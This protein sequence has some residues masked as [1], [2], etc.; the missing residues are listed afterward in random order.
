MNDKRRSTVNLS[1]TLVVLLVVACGTPQPTPT[2]VPPTLTPVPPTSTPVPPTATLTPLPPT[3]SPT[4][5][6]PTSPSQIDREGLVAYFPFDGDADDASGNGHH[7]TVHGATLTTDR[8]GEDARAYAFDGVD[9]FVSIP[10]SPD[11]DI[12]AG[13]MTVLLWALLEAGP[14]FRGLISHTN[15]DEAN[16]GWWWTV[17]YVRDAMWVCMDD[18][19]HILRKELPL[20]TWIHLAFVKSGSEITFYID[21]VATGNPLDLRKT[22]NDSDGHLR[23]GREGST[24]EDR[25]GEILFLGKIDDVRFYNRAFTTHEILAAM[26]VP[27]TE[28]GGA[29][30]PPTYLAQLEPETVKVGWGRFAVGVYESTS[31]DPADKM[32]KGDPIVVHGVEYPHGLLAHAPSQLVYDLGGNFSELEVTIG[33]VDWIECGDG[34]QFIIRLDG[35]EI[36]RSPTMLASSVPIEVKVSVAQGQKLELLTDHGRAKNRYCDNTIWGD[37]IL[38]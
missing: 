14:R 33:L 16:D 6:P 22:I 30:G 26:I 4:P 34:A 5:L 38:R 17:D 32:R 18:R 13:D 7:G 24:Y 37:P 3:P 12:G 31:P 20:D 35:N 29:S 27:E 28:L 15:G 11:F 9:D 25:H 21:G 8:Y 1:L 10:D 19:D 23:I 36:Y 2:P